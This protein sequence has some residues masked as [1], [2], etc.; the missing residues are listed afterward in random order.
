MVRWG[1]TTHQSGGEDRD[2]DT[3]SA[4]P[5]SVSSVEAK[6]QH[7]NQE[8]TSLFI[9]FLNLLFSLLSETKR[10]QSDLALALFCK[11]QPGLLQTPLCLYETREGILAESVTRPRWVV[12]A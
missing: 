2:T 11:E 1:D 5:F 8:M 10:L 3:F 12:G 6:E 9:W 7:R 4:V